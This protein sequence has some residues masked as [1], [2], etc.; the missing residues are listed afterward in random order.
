[1]RIVLLLLAT[2]SMTRAFAGEVATDT[3]VRV[4]GIYRTEKVL[5]PEPART[6]D[7]RVFD[8][9]HEYLRFFSDG[10]VLSASKPEAIGEQ[11]DLPS[12]SNWLSKENPAISRGVY[13]AHGGLVTFSI[14]SNAGTVSYSGSP[15]GENLSV[16]WRSEINGRSG[17][18]QYSFV[19]LAR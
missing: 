3:A 19:A 15:D 13:T 7:G 8:G 11:T 9:I 2:L 18:R 4:D 16:E 17:V 12:I 14:A 10:T 5:F 6:K 1:M